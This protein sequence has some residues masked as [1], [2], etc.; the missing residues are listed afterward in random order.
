[1]S[2]DPLNGRCAS[3]VYGRLRASGYRLTAPR[4]ALVDALLAADGPLCADQVHARVQGRGLNLSTVYR[5]LGQFVAMGWLEALPGVNG[6]R[7][8][9]V[10]STDPHSITVVCLDC[11]RINLLPAEVPDLA[12]AAAGLGYRADSVHV[13]LSA[14]CDQKCAGAA[15]LSCLKAG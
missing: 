11:G 15:G 4:R 5:N 8:Y 6:E 2:P 12:A 1:M 10:R 3:D 14:H 9:G 13:T 7:R